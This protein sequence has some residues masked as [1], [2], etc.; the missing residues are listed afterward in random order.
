MGG[1]PLLGFDVAN[2]KLVINDPE[3]KLVRRIFTR[4]IAL[5]GSTYIVDVLSLRSFRTVRELKLEGLTIKS[6]TTQSGK[7]RVGTT[8]TKSL[9]YKLLQNPTYLGELKHRSD[10][11]TSEYAPIISVALIESAKAILSTTKRV[12]GNHT[13]S[14]THFLLK[15]IVFGSDGRSL[16]RWHSVKKSGRKYRY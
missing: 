9:I 7:H 15:G 3:A 12:R 6:W 1:I 11:V 13:R 8:I 2:Q 10:W 14:R 16:S 4:F 5:G